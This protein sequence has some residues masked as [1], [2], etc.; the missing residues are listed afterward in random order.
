MN[1]LGRP[2]EALDFA[3][4]AER[5]TP[6]RPPMY[7]AIVAQSLYGAERYE[8]AIAA[9][10]ATIELDARGVEH[11]ADRRAQALHL[12]LDAVR[13]LARAFRVVGDAVAQQLGHRAHRRDR[14][15]ELV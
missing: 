4:Y 5:L 12:V 8:D 2:A 13:V 9:A 14:C 11:V 10:S 7:P 3:L 15:L 6:V 1:Y